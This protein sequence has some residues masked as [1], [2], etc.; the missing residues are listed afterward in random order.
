MLLNKGH[1]VTR[2]VPVFGIKDYIVYYF[3]IKELEDILCGNRTVNTFGG[4][5][6][7]GE[8]RRKEDCDIECEATEYGRYSF[9]PRAWKHA[10]GEFTSLLYAQI[11]SGVYSHVLQFDLSNF[12][13]SI[14]L[15]TL[16]RSIREADHNDMGWII[17]LLFYLL[18]NWNRRNTGLHRQAVGLPQDALA[19]C[20]RILANFYL[21]KYDAFASCVCTKAGGLYFRYSDD[22]MI[23][24][25]DVNKCDGLLL[26][27]TRKLDRFGLRVNQKKVEL[28][29]SEG[30][31]AHRCRSVHRVFEKTKDTKNPELVKSSVKEYLSLSLDDLKRTWNGGMPV[32]NRLI[33]A[34]IE[35]LPDDLF[36]QVLDRL[37]ST[38]YLLMA[39]SKKLARIE[40]LVRSRKPEVN[41]RDVLIELGAKAVH[42]AFHHEVVS[43]AIAANDDNLNDIFQERLRS[44]EVQMLG[45]EIV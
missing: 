35:S 42:N 6:L 20:S 22:Q 2:T 18:N 44:L 16:E 23:L 41:F 37:L 19:D 15:D 7:G 1:G 30:I 14:R 45:D 36:G 43:F 29:T 26:L 10:F 33:W 3:C 25:N 13:D 39:D 9:D 8:L 38:D 28:W 27:L 4:W 17:T 34:N 21:Q 24:L 40:A 5:S 32:L 12:Y 31:Q 11:D